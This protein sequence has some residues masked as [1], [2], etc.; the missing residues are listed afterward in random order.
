MISLMLHAEIYSDSTINDAISAYGELAVINKTGVDHGYI[1]LDFVEC[2]YQ[3]I[4]TVKEF[5]NY[6]IDLENS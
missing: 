4:K 1:K 6:M 5:E 3:E 2:K